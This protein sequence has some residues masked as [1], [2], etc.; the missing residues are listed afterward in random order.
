M[1]NDER[2]R[3]TAAWLNIVAAGVISTGSLTQ[4]IAVSVGDRA[5]ASAAPSIAGA[6][7]SLGA[8]I[9]LH[10]VARALIRTGPEH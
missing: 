10:L 9:A 3:L 6:L 8:G 1:T 2:Q 4:L 7:A 5:G